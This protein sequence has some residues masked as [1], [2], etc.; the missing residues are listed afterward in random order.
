M[1]KIASGAHGP[2][3]EANRGTKLI[4]GC[5][6]Y[7]D[8]DTYR[9]RAPPQSEGEGGEELNRNRLPRGGDTWI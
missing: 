2:V 7:N 4:T 3:Q 1:V 9:R 5:A 8:G 6:G